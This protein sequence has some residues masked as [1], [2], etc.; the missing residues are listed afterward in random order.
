[1]VLFKKI[2]FFFIGLII[3]DF[4]MGGSWALVGLFSHASYQVLPT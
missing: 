2:R 4:L 1:V 3:G